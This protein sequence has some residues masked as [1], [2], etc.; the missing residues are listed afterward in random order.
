MFKILLGIKKLSALFSEIVSK[1]SDII[2]APFILSKKKA[3][4]FS[5]LIKDTSNSIHV[6][7][8]INCA[9]AISLAL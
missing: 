7:K 8:R 3:N 5:T 2:F 9:L 1:F 6:F 4:C